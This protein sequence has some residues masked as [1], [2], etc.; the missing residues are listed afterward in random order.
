MIASKVIKCLNTTNFSKC[1]VHSQPF[2]VQYDIHVYS[3]TS[4]YFRD[5]YYELLL[6]FVKRSFVVKVS[7]TFQTSVL[8]L[9]QL[10]LECP[11]VRPSFPSEDITFFTSQKSVK[12]S[13][14]VSGNILFLTVQR[15][16]ND[17]LYILYH[18]YSNFAPGII[19]CPVPGLHY[20]KSAK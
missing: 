16:E 5:V 19:N 7:A 11:Y 4:F 8:W 15:I 13:M 1:I 3:L 14:D 2:K 6:Q 18:D 17:P 20:N 10:I 12:L 9:F